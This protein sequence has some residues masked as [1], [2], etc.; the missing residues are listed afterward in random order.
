MLLAVPTGAAATGHAGGVP[1]LDYS[2]GSFADFIVSSDPALAGT[3]WAEPE[4]AGPELAD[5]ELA[6][7]G[8]AEAPVS[9]PPSSTRPMDMSSAAGPANGTSAQPME[10][11]RSHSPGS[12]PW[13]AARPDVLIGLPP[14][15]GDAAKTQP[16]PEPERPRRRSRLLL[17]A[18]VLIILAGVGAVGVLTLRHHPTRALVATP[19][20]RPNGTT[21]RRSPTASAAASAKARLSAPVPSAA[22]PV[23]AA[24]VPIDQ[25]ALHA[26]G[27]VITGVSCS[28]PETCYA[29]DSAGNVL[30]FT[31]ASSVGASSTSPSAAAP[32]STVPSSTGGTWHVVATDPR[33]GLV[34]ISCPT[35][36]FCLAVD[37]S[38]NAITLSHGTWSSPVYVDARVG[39]FTAVSC[40]A[41]TFCVATDSGG[42]AFAYTPPSRAWQPYTVDSSGGGLTGVSCPSTGFCAA[43]DSGGG[44][45]T[46]DGSTW[47]AV[48][49][50]D[51]GHVF[52]AV[53]CA[54]PAFCVAADAAGKAAVL[55]G[56]KWT[57]GPM[58]TTA[59]AVACPGD[60]FCLATDGSGGVVTYRNGG[61]S[62]VS[63]IDGNAAID[64]LSCPALTACTAADQ[65]D[66][67]L[68]YGPAQ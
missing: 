35:A 36:G 67:V 28:Q 38:G 52:T 44:T 17:T 50:V 65:K 58:G 1:V 56:G 57:V 40:P 62:P 6:E 46:F 12:G 59:L 19:S 24:P 25:A 68:Y 32:S 3:G 54:S 29:V 9:E 10:S 14:L 49:P 4:V 20:P 2:T 47:S 41:T 63:K 64:T 18:L 22:P 5:P 45:Y 21:A 23:W 61:W 34:A 30:A 60:G 7:P 8:L 42:N 66:N 39:T 43:V 13:P 48:S 37:K 55:S 27:A 31:G 33:N 15:G 51:A 11:F 26:R 53:S 16:S